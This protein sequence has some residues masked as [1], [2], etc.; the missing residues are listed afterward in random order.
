KIVS[1][2]TCVLML[3]VFVP[4]PTIADQTQYIYDDLGLLSQVIDGQGNV[5][6]YNRQRRGLRKR[7]AHPHESDRRVARHKQSRHSR[8]MGRVT[9]HQQHMGLYAKTRRSVA[10]FRPTP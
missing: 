4:I 2:V 9:L 8:A 7:L 10:F 6:T 3:C 1:V 5:A